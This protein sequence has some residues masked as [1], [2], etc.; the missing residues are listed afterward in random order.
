MHTEKDSLP[1]I[2]IQGV[3]KA[4]Q[5]SRITVEVAGSGLLQRLA[6]R[7]GRANGSGVLNGAGQR[8]AGGAPCASVSAS[9]GATAAARAPC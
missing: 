3:S 8:F 9:S 4:Y 6:G 7:A 5:L 2:S 1:A